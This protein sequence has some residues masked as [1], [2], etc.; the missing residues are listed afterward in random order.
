MTTAFHAPPQRRRKTL[1]EANLLEGPML[2]LKSIRGFSSNRAMTWLA[3]APLALMGLG[4]FTLS[5]KAEELP[6]KR[7]IA[8]IRHVALVYLRDVTTS[9]K[10]FLPLYRQI[11]QNQR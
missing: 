6:S 1:Q 8:Q 7:E 5:A 3:C 2:L 11:I 10:P 4:I 9:R